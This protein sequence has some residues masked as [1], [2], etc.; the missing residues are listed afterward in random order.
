MNFE[1]YRP[2]SD[3]TAD[4]IE[5][6][7]QI[8]M[9]DGRVLND[10]EADDLV[11]RLITA[12]GRPSLTAP[13]IHSPTISMRLD[14]AMAQKLDAQAAKEG[15]RRSDLIRDAVANYLHSA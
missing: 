11:E 6:V 12:S 8:T 3:L 4:D 15:R 9:S 2:T 7:D 10:E 5:D 14:A 13:G 1:R